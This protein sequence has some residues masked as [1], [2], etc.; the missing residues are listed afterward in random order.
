MN[1]AHQKLLQR[2]GSM[3]L[4]IILVTSCTNKPDTL[5]TDSTLTIDALPS[6]TSTESPPPLISEGYGAKGADLQTEFTLE[7]MMKY[8]LEDEYLAYAEYEL[9][10]S[11][12]DVTRP[13]SNII[14]AEATHIKYMEDLYDVYGY[15]LPSVDPSQHILLPDS[16]NEAFIAGVDAEVINI[17]MYEKFLEQDLP[18]D[19][20]EVF[21]RLKAG[22]E[23]HLKAFQKNVR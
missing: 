20:R 1:Y 17:A 16:T 3:F 13:F 9:I 8:A 6:T 18:D 10:L 12:M 14:K 21:E 5:T 4:L 15:E 2:L 11:E 19:V 23:S 7:E 22:S